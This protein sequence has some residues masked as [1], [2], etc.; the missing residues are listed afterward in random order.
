MHKLEWISL[1]L[2]YSLK[3]FIFKIIAYGLKDAENENILEFS[4]FALIS[5]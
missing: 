5:G 1:I 3:Y 2:L 4:W